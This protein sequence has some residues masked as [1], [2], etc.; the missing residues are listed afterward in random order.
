MNTKFKDF[1][2]NYSKV[3]FIFD[4]KLSIY[5]FISF[6]L[7]TI[8]GTLSHE[9]GHHLAG[10]I[11]GIKTRVNYAYTIPI[12]YEGNKRI[13]EIRELEKYYY[14]Y[15]AINLENI[16]IIKQHEIVRK[17]EN[18]YIIFTLGGPLQTMLT[19]I[20]GLFILFFFKK[21]YFD[22]IG[23]VFW[24]WLIVFISLFW[25][26]QS[27]NMFTGLFF[28]LINGRAGTMSDEIKLARDFGL[29]PE[30]LSIITGVIGL[31][32]LAIVVFNFIPLK[33]RFTFLI[34]GLI[35]GVAGYY[36]WLIQF[37]KIIMP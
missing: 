34:S 20:I 16:Y 14:I 21:K 29:P 31:I 10:N 12:D 11:I 15:K 4:Y 13:K 5:L 25:L 26:R 27:A 32:I 33:Q 18:E 35:G 9:Y 24:Q 19:S 3:E 8:I 30:T 23:L 28:H 37:G 22:A 6:I 36:L 17:M 2:L 7:F 1:I